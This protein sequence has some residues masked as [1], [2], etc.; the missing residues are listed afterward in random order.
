MQIT[1]N[2]MDWEEVKGFARQVLKGE[3]SPEQ[4]PAPVSVPQPVPNT[5]QSPPVTPP[6]VQPPVTVATTPATYLLE[7]LT[8]AAMSLMDKGMQAQLQQL[9]AS[10]GVASLVELSPDRYGE[11]ALALRAMGASI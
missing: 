3:V 1:I 5:T 2:F 10:F 9:V 7:D 4:A 8:H 6:P 11:F